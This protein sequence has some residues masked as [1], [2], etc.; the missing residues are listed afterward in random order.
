[1]QRF[2][3]SL[4]LIIGFQQA[5]SQAK[6]N[7]VQ[8]Y[9]AQL[10]RE[11]GIN[12]IFM[13]DLDKSGKKP[14][15]Y[16]NNAAERIKVDNVI[17]KGDSVIVKMPLFESTF[18][19][20][21]LKG[22]WKGIWTRKTSTDDRIIPFIAE[23]A[24]NRFALDEGP[25]KININGRWEANFESDSSETATNVAE[26][27]H[28]GNRLVGSFLT[29]YGDYRYLEGVVT[30]NKLKLSSFDGSN[31]YLFL[32]D[33]ID[34][35]TIANGVFYS[36]ST[37]TDKWT[38][39]KNSKAVVQSDLSAMYLRKGESKLNFTFPNL[40]SNLV[41]IKD[42]R[43]KNKVVVIQLMGSWCSNCMDESVFLGEFYRNN[44]Q[45]GVEV[46]GLAYEY[47]NDF[48]RAQNL[49]GK[50]K[51][52]LKLDYPILVT[53]V[54]SSDTLR[55]EKTL[56]QLTPIKVFPSSIILDK[57]GN[58]RKLD[59]GFY[60]PGTGNHYEKYKKDFSDYIDKLLGE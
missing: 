7:G 59:N 57:E 33:I 54:T 16:V 58:V 60:G 4:L 21:V 45:R 24:G 47:S 53:G 23:P 43:Y 49:L 20:R 55:T 29:P 44:K 6:T 25:A 42:D 50:L 36:G 19:A 41:S 40:D 15:V 9:K 10:Q 35:K 5:F 52:R 2:I 17:F 8:T 26:F 18:R 39:I 28:S 37:S 46:I 27:W 34:N 38:A 3:I 11:D 14:V 31:A 56:P 12:I 48:K 13:F 30:G 22:N 51:Q 32:A 1:M